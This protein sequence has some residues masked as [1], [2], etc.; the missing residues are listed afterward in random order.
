MSYQYG[1]DS[2]WPSDPLGDTAPLLVQLSFHDDENRVSADELVEWT[3]HSLKYV[4]ISLDTLLLA[5]WTDDD[6]EAPVHADVKRFQNSTG[7]AVEIDI[8][9]LHDFAHSHEDQAKALSSETTT[10]LSR[11]AVLGVDR[12][13]RIELEKRGVV[14]ETLSLSCS[15]L[16]LARL[17]IAHVRLFHQR[18]AHLNYRIVSVESGNANPHWVC[19]VT[20]FNATYT[21]FIKNSLYDVGFRTSGPTRKLEFGDSID[22]T[23][24]WY[25]I[26]LIPWTD[27]KEFI[28]DESD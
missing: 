27:P 1:T 9:P 23:G 15:P 2:P 19:F 18:R 26:D 22:M 20:S 11:H 14:Q 25:A 3:R 13:I 7:I 6:I 21:F 24:D 12:S 17:C 4:L 16:L 8:R 28:H 5:A 10:L